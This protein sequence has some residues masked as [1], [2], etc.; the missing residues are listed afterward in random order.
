MHSPWLW[1]AAGLL[2]FIVLV[3]IGTHPDSLPQWM[4]GSLRSTKP[5]GPSIKVALPPLNTSRVAVM[6]EKEAK[7]NLV[8][9]L[10]NF[11]RI[12]P[13]EW[14]F[15]VYTGVE[16]HEVLS[17]AK[18]MAPFLDSGKLT[19]K[20]LPDEDSIYN[21]PTLSTFLAS[22]SDFWDSLPREAEQVLVFDINSI[23]C[24]NA[25]LNINDFLG[26]DVF[27]GGY[28]WL[29]TPWSFR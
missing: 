4:G 19:L 27:P 17:Q 25:E 29:A 2:G 10:F 23:M 5:T 24:S 12:V 8:P 26:F 6:I 28:A 21:S 22:N 13:E 9:V 15:V 11:L 16:S 7:S 1:G 3:A 18:L 14:P 20:P